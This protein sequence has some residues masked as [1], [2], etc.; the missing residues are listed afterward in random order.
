MAQKR[1]LKCKG[2]ERD[3]MAVTKEST[4]TAVRLLV[5][6]LVAGQKEGWGRYPAIADREG[7]EA[8]F[9][10]DETEGEEGRSSEATLIS[11][12]GAARSCSSGFSAACSVPSSRCEGRV[13]SDRWVFQPWSSTEK[14]KFQ[15]FSDRGFGVAVLGCSSVRSIRSKH[16]GNGKQLDWRVRTKQQPVILLIHFFLFGIQSKGWRHW[17]NDWSRG[18]LGKNENGLRWWLTDPAKEEN[19]KKT[20][21]KIC[22]AVKKWM[23]GK[24]IVSFGVWFSTWKWRRRRVER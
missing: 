14:K 13:I 1:R 4:K 20:N 8:V 18:C 11:E 21:G 9:G 22:L 16:D 24:R 15:G 23:K 10:V 3:M 6:L 2:N 17:Q 19:K 5:S 12:K 7:E